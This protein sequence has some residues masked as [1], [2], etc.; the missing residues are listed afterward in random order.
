MTAP[1]TSMNTLI[2]GL[3]R[4]GKTTLA[5]ELVKGKRYLFLDPRGQLQRN[6]LLH[7]ER[8]NELPL[9][10]LQDFL[11]GKIY[12]LGLHIPRE[13]CERVFAILRGMSDDFREMDF[14]LVVDESQ[15]FMHSNYIQPDL[16]ELI[17]TGGQNRLNIMLIV[18]DAHEVHKFARTQSDVIISFRQK[19]PAALDW[20]SKLHEEAR[21]T[22]PTLE[23]GEYVYLVEAD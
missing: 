15:F 3:K 19:E 20:C 11:N 8:R 22:L 13:E 21:A 1:I 10:E 14:T 16:E 5:F 4:Y 12:A 2:L 18:R 23:R 9:R 6:G 17:A 7:V